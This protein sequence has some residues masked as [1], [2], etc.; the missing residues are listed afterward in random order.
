MRCINAV[1]RGYEEPASTSTSNLDAA[2]SHSV[3]LHWE[4]PPLSSPW[5]VVY[6]PSSGAYGDSAASTLV[7]ARYLHT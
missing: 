2:Q 1:T 7:V 6:R 4:S 5:D 3:Y